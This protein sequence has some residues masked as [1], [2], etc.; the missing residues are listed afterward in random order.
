MFQGWPSKFC[1]NL[2]RLWFPDTITSSH[3]MVCHS[4]IQPS[5]CLKI[6]SYL[7]VKLMI[8]AASVKMVVIFSYVISV[9]EYFTRVKFHLFFLYDYLSLNCLLIV[10]FHLV[11][12][13][14]G[15][16]EIPEGDWYCQWCMNLYP[17]GK[18]ACQRNNARAAG[19]VVD[20]EPIEQIYQRCCQV[21]T[22]RGDYVG[23]CAICKL[24]SPYMHAIS[25]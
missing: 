15:L 21:I 17:E 23:G 20:V 22:E 8:F 14:V 7:L 18:Q 5:P 12:E 3:W 11:A 2:S 25:C 24:V 16:L 13:C 6:E 10:S 4:M 19:R 1:T 9:P